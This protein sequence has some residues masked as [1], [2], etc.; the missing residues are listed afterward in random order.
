[1]IDFEDRWTKKSLIGFLVFAA[2]ALGVPHS[3]KAKLWGEVVHSAKAG[4]KH[5]VSRGGRHA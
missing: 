5:I 2:L 1:M 4:F 3:S